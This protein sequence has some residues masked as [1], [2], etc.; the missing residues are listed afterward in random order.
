MTNWQN[1]RIQSAIDGMNPMVM[2]HLPGGIAVYGDTQFLPGYS[3]LLPNRQVASLNELTLAESTAFLQSMRILGDAILQAT[4]CERINY[5]ILGNTDQFLHAHVFPRYITE[6]PTRRV[7]P[8]W[9]YSPDH[10][11][12]DQYHYD[13]DRDG[14]LRQAITQILNR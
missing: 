12:D 6:S 9:L 14:P 4:G 13:T 8:V 11:Y 10:W 3:V 1:N 7:K 2:A 5:D